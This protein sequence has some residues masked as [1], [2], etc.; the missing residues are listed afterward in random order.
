MV[1]RYAQAKMPGK[2]EKSIRCNVPG[3]FLMP[4]NNGLFTHKAAVKM[5]AAFDIPA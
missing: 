2:R 5:T 3:A 1:Y 4:I